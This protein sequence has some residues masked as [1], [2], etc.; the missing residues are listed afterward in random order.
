MIYTG[1]VACTKLRLTK[2]DALKERD[3]INAFLPDKTRVFHI[4]VESPDNKV[5]TLITKEIQ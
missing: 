1:W 2:E 3:E 5:T 4:N